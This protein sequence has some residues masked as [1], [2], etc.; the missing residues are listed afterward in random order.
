MTEMFNNFLLLTEF[1][2]TK[3][4]QVGRSAH[5]N[6]AKSIAIHYS[7]DTSKYANGNYEN[8]K[9]ELII[10]IQMFDFCG[11]HI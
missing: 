4:L 1:F 8:Y 3:L 11:H 7:G 10:E 6:R 9:G 5:Q 2:N